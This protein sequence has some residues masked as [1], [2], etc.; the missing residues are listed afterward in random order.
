MRRKRGFTI[1]ELIIAVTVTALL[2]AVALP[3]YNGFLRQQEFNASAQGLVIC[4][5]TAQREAASPTYLGAATP[6]IRFTGALVEEVGSGDLRCTVTYYTATTTADK[7]A[8]GTATPVYSKTSTQ[9]ANISLFSATAKS[10]AGNIIVYGTDSNT[11]VTSVYFGA[12]EQGTPIV[13]RACSDLAHGCG[14]LAPPDLTFG[15]GL[16]LSLALTYPTSTEIIQTV[17]MEK[18]GLPI[19]LSK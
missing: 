7:L 8:D 10:S 6:S 16:S 18:T 1:I 19:Q 15:K 13:F 11:M 5:Q 2:V 3:R 9:L 17:T 12:L 4:L 14:G